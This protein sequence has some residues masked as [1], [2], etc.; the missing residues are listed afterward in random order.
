MMSCLVE[1]PSIIFKQSGGVAAAGDEDTGEDEA[2]PSGIV[3]V[4]ALSTGE[5]LCGNAEVSD[6]SSVATVM[7]CEMLGVTFV[8]PVCS[9]LLRVDVKY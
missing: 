6:R 3:T 4:C 5:E 9:A 8:M 1:G 7:S 2:G